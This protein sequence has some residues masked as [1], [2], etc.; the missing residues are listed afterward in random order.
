MFVTVAGKPIRASKR[1][2]EWCLKAVDQCWSQKERAIR[3]AEK[4]AAR[5]AYD[6]A[7]QAYRKVLAESD[8]D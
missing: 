2:A 8:I 5:Q 1:S 7:R 6:V 4:D 3:P